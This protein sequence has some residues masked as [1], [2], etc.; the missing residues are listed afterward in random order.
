MDIYIS[1]SLLSAL[2]SFLLAAQLYKL[3]KNKQ[4]FWF[5][6]VMASTG[7][8]SF[9]GVLW[10]LL[11]ESLEIILVNFSYIGIITLPVFLLYFAI[12]YTQ[13]IADLPNRKWLKLLWV[14]PIV[15]ILLM[16]TNDLHGW[17]WSSITE[18][19]L[20]NQTVIKD[21][22]PGFWFWIH[23]AYSYSLVMA[24]VVLLLL[25]FRKQKVFANQ[26][27]LLAGIL[28][29][30]TTSVLYVFEITVMDFSPLVLSFTIM[31]AAWAISGRF[32][33]RNVQEVEV[34]Q[35]KTSA[36]NKLYSLVVKISEKL[37]QADPEQMDA[38]VTEA[39]GD[40]GKFSD[41]DRVYLFKYDDVADTVSNSHEWCRDGITP[42]MEN[43]Q[44]VPFKDS[45]PRW[46]KHFLDNKYIYIPLI[47]DLPDDPLYAEEK[48]IL[49][50]QGI[51]SLIAV[52]MHYGKRFFGFA[53][54]DSVLHQRTWDDE[55]IALLRLVANIMAGNLVRAAFEKELQTALSKAE[56]ANRAKTEFLAN[57]SHEL[58]TP[59]TA[60]IGLTSLV[61]DNITDH[62]QKEDLGMVM[63]SGN[64]LLKLINDLLD[65]SRAEA[66]LLELQP[67]PVE[68]LKELHFLK[69]LF[70]P[71]YRE[72]KLCL[73]VSVPENVRLPFML[74]KR[75]LRQILFNIIGNA[76]KFT[77]K[78][79]VTLSA[80]TIP[81][82]TKHHTL[83]IHIEDTGIGIP[84][85]DQGKI[86]HL[87][88]QLSTGNAREY[89]GTG[90]GL[91]VSLRLVK[92]M[93]G[94]I[95][96]ESEPEKGSR[97]TVKL[98]GIP[99]A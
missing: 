14:I 73:Q 29:P 69:K 20:F 84:A 8:W 45:V 40:L 33:M 53:G 13:G 65:F 77:K 68:L 4:F 63:D 19:K 90:L 7:V 93:G 61:A 17:F 26:Y 46:S 55:S 83:L 71:Q 72:K 75:R 21:F 62:E 43:L 52:P 42:E 87:F 6:P 48:T 60:V 70:T 22:N 36:L 59:L 30:F 57:L 38:S 1:L 80:E 18:D 58:R 9:F 82:K 2:L 35:K 78:G 10:L 66:G 97:F 54:F 24:S 94:D 39:L 88:T 47:A 27:A 25:N 49:E 64:A 16:F 96:V 50:P 31:A 79:H 51:K 91:N 89:E 81:E 44:N 5:L 67:E 95:L 74:D 41:V 32:Y 34:L 12:D 86:F 98:T 11:P 37:A 85:E 56:A 76:I 15:S 3:D 28:L 23:A 99:L 92:L